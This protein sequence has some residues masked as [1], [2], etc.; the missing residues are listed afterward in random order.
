MECKS[1]FLLAPSP[2]P[3]NFVLQ[4]VGEKQADESWEDRQGRGNR[5]TEHLSE[6]GINRFA[7]LMHRKCDWLLLE[8]YGAALFFPHG[9]EETW[10]KSGVGG[11]TASPNPSRLKKVRLLLHLLQRGNKQR[12]RKKKKKPCCS[13]LP[14]PTYVTRIGRGERTEGAFTE[15]RA[16][17]GAHIGRCSVDGATAPP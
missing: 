13:Y 12:E 1:L 3:P 4:R 9:E 7:S 16:L 2:S 10:G 6:G 14:V 15:A 8:C 17:I 5:R 11:R